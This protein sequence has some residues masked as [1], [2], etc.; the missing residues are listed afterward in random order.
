[1][2]TTYQNQFASIC[3]SYVEARQ[4]ERAEKAQRRQDI[5]KSLEDGVSRVYT[6][7]VVPTARS[8]GNALKYL[9][10]KVWEGT[11]AV[12]RGVKTG[13]KTTARGIGRAAELYALA[14]EYDEIRSGYYSK[15]N[16]GRPTEERIRDPKEVYREQAKEAERTA[17]KRGKTYKQS[18]GLASRILG[19]KGKKLNGLR[20]E[21]MDSQE[22]SS[23]NRRRNAYINAEAQAKEMNTEEGFLG[24]F[25]TGIRQARRAEQ[26]EQIAEQARAMGVEGINPN[27]LYSAL[28]QGD[29][30]TASKFQKKKKDEKKAK[31]KLNPQTGNIEGEGI[32]TFDDVM[33]LM[34]AMGTQENA[35]TARELRMEEMDIRRQEALFNMMLNAWYYSGRREDFGEWYQRQRNYGQPNQNSTNTNATSPTGI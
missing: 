35:R 17:E 25:A 7:V 34:Q 8:T 33:K 13:A 30:A 9:G 5:A 16:E 19:R 6:G 1:M 31:F 18:Y 20:I 15:L 23:F 26:L 22:K 4:F 12:G 24:R 29:L 21:D 3:A 14:K 10:G 11:K 28:D 32:E 27:F 2:N